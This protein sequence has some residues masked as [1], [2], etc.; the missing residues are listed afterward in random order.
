VKLG[1]TLGFRND[2]GSLGGRRRP[3][4][5]VTTC[6]TA[7]DR[8]M[9]TRAPA[10]ESS[11]VK[12]RE[13]VFTVSV[14]PSAL[15]DPL[16]GAKTVLDGLLRRHVG[17]LGGVLMSRDRE[18]LYGGDE[19]DEEGEGGKRKRDVDDASAPGTSSD[20]ETSGSG[21]GSGS[22]SDS[23]DASTDGRADGLTR[24]RFG[25]VIHTAGYVDVCVRSTC[26]VFLP[27]RGSRLVGVVNK[28]A[29]DFIG[30]L[31]LD[32]FNVAIASDNIREELVSCSEEGCW[33]SAWDDAHTLRVGSQV[34]F[35]VKSVSETD[36]VVLLVGALLE[37][38]TGEREYVGRNSSGITSI[39]RKLQQGKK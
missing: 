7:T 10:V 24:A 38:G 34:V 28:I 36:D 9:S 33:K 16:A 31:V 2:G 35:T 14:H 5:T 8:T 25:R 37:E 18:R 17:E 1:F 3:R 23:E 32:K 12:T 4:H 21:S 19:D 20:A 6:A 22:S 29:H 39:E 30:A 11:A 26:K 27:V 13:C 15:A